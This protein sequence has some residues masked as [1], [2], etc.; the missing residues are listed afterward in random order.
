MPIHRD[1]FAG[2]MNSRIGR[3]LHRA[4]LR[5]FCDAPQAIALMASDG[6][7]QAVGYVVGAPARL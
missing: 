7:G 3:G 6:D 4:F 1:A 2:Y 5:W